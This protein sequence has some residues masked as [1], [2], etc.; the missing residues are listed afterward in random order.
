MHDT[1]T[2]VPSPDHADLPTLD[3]RSLLVFGAVGRHGSMSAA[4][5][6]IGWTQP[7]VSQH[8]RRL[9]RTMQVPLIARQGRGIELTGPG[10][11]LLRYAE[12]IAATLR[13]AEQRMR[14]HARAEAG[15]VRIA[16]FPSA[17]ASIVSPSVRK[18][19]RNHPGLELAL[20]QLEPPDAMRLLA[21]GACDIAIIFE[22]AEERL[23]TAGFSVHPLTDDPLLAVLPA[24]HP[25][26]GAPSIELGALA[27]ARWVS[28]CPDCRQHLL[29][30]TARRGFVPDIRHSTDDYVVVQALVAD[31]AAVAVLPALAL[32]AS[33]NPGVVAVP[34]VDE[35]PRR[36]LALTRPGTAG[37]PAVHAVLTTLRS[38]SE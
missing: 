1:N 18:L 31:D 22:Y 34:I 35:A 30:A 23:D 9:E 25:E 26:R 8:V 14:A 2:P 38:L 33:T 6:A 13:D 36:V 28:G 4:A 37:V 5:A 12:G 19:G 20:T 7:A 17:M 16:A 3:P 15:V 24:S 32:A 21:E 27:G 29:H 10:R 11:D